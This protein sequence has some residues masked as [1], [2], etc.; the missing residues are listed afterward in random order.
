MVNFHGYVKL[1]EGI[2][3][4]IT[5]SVDCI[6]GYP[7]IRYIDPCCTDF[8][9]QSHLQA[10]CR[11]VLRVPGLHHDVARW[12]MVGGDSNLPRLESNFENLQKSLSH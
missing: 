2:S 6:H 12:A 3:N 7:Q 5:P 11:D 4:T 8:V 10:A 9:S 1:P